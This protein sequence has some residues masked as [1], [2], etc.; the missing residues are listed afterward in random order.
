MSSYVLVWS[1]TCLVNDFRRSAVATKRR[2]LLNEM[3]F[4]GSISNMDHRETVVFHKLTS[5][6]LL[7]FSENSVC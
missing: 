6:K 2:A 4:L 1:L 3:P 5:S 7:P